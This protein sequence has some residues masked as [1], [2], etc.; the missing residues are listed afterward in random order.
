MA[1]INKRLLERLQK[2][3]DVGQ[4]RVYRVIA[5]KAQETLLPRHLAAVKLA[6]EHGI[7]VSRMATAEELAEIRQASQ[8]SQTSALPIQSVRLPKSQPT[9]KKGKSKRSDKKR[10]KASTRRGTSVYVVHGRNDKMRR[11]MF[12]FL[13]SVGLTPIEWR[14]AIK[15]AGKPSPFVSEI[16]DAAFREAVAIV[17]LLTPDDEVRLK[18][19][20]QKSNDPQYEKTLTGQ[21]RPNVLFEAGMAFGRNPG[22]TV[23]VEVGAVKHFSDV[24]GRHVVHLTNSTESRHELITKLA[25][26]GCNVDAGGTDWHSE[27]DF[28]LDTKPKPHR[29]FGFEEL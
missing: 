20:F 14:K 10:T 25:N 23:L 21:A 13:R 28:K 19:E 4:D 27:G 2:K 11:A 16:V 7:N 1:R 15:L 12:S 24:A 18:K 6:A 22:S 8:G 9:N 5:T 17:V 26:A 29:G 3:L